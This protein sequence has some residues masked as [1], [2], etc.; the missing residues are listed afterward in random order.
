MVGP[1]R[2]RSFVGEVFHLYDRWSSQI[3]IYL[4]ILV[5]STSL[6]LVLDLQFGVPPALVLLFM[7]PV[8]A[9]MLFAV[10]AAYVAVSHAVERSSS[11]GGDAAPT[12]LR[13]GK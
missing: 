4:T 2:K 1:A 3:A 11:D 12:L 10:P 13:S 7:T 8:V 5:L 6:A 9:I